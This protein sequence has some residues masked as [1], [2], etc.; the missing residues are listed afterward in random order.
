MPIST[1]FNMADFCSIVKFSRLCLLLPLFISCLVVE[2]D[3]RG[4][5]LAQRTTRNK[6]TIQNTY[7]LQF[8]TISAVPTQN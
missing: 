6:A 1:A 7:I 3:I 4:V 2:T 8:A 5:A